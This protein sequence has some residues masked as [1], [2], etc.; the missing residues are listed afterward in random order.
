MINEKLVTKSIIKSLAGKPL[1]SLEPDVAIC[2]TGFSELV[3]AY[4]L[5]K[6]GLTMAE[7]TADSPKP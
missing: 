5:T 6:K 4:F 7:L 1:P 2:H 3:A